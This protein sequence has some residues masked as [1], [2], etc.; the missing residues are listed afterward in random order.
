MSLHVEQPQVEPGVSFV[1]LM[2]GHLLIFSCTYVNSINEI[3][4]LDG[5]MCYCIFK[6]SHGA[7]FYIMCISFYF[8]Y[9]FFNSRIL[10]K[11]LNIIL[12]FCIH[13]L[14]DLNGFLFIAFHAIP[15]PFF[16]YEI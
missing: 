4:I 1:I 10:Y 5:D 15:I 3:I 2:I 8:I 6:E 14:M 7:S 12:F 16:L 9:L 13:M 11:N